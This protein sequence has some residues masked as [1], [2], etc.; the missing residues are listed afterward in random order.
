M[1]EPAGALFAGT[2]GLD[3]YRAIA[4]L[5]APQIATGGMACIEIGHDQA[6]AAGALFAA[7]GLEARVMR[8]LGARDRCLVLTR[9]RA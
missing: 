6:E 1:Y 7:T 8:D 9:S 4:P 5:L 3:A 2:D